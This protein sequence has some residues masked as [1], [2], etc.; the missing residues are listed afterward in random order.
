[1]IVCLNF[2]VGDEKPVVCQDSIT[3]NVSIRTAF[4]IT[5]NGANNNIGGSTYSALFLQGIEDN[6]SGTFGS[7]EVSTYAGES[8]K[9][10]KVNIGQVNLNA[11]SDKSCQTSPLGL[12]FLW[13]TNNPGKITM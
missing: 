10:L 11:K 1:M 9:G 5:G 6:W 12:N 2:G 3:G 8:S 13:S 4:N 7:Y